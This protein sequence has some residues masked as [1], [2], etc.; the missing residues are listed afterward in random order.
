MKLS[1][2]AIIARL[3]ELLLAEVS[4]PIAQ[5]QSEVSEARQ[6]ATARAREMSNRSVYR[7]QR[8]EVRS[9]Y[10]PFTDAYTPVYDPVEFV[11]LRY[12]DLDA[13]SKHHGI[14]RDT[15]QAALE[16]RVKE[17]VDKDGSIWRASPWMWHDSSIADQD[18]QEML[19]ADEKERKALQ[20]RLDRGKQAASMPL[21]TLDKFMHEDTPI[22]GKTI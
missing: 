11:E 19:E 1:H 17:A 12:A 3:A 16:N 10:N 5:L 15:L 6:E 14:D 2:D 20:K 22:A 9:V 21:N 13:F 8:V 7:G 18:R 4:N